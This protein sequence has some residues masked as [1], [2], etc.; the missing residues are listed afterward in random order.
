ML[1]PGSQLSNTAF[2]PPAA[3][4]DCD[5]SEENGETRITSMF[6]CAHSMAH[7]SPAIPLPIIKTFFMIFT[8]CN[9]L[10]VFPKELFC[11]RS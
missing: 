6:L 4:T 11:D 7:V 2:I 9:E 5:L 3:S 1:S 8:S 10:S